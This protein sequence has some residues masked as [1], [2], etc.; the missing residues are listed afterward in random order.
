MIVT[1]EYVAYD[2]AGHYYY[3]TEAGLAKY[4]ISGEELIKLWKQPLKRL[5]LQGRLLHNKMVKSAYNGKL[6]RYRHKDIIE[7][8]VYLDLYGE[9]DAVLEALTNFAEIVSDSELDRDLLDGT[10]VWPESVL[11]PLRD[12]MIYYTGEIFQIVPEDEYQ[13]GY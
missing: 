9:R 2:T 12:A 8:N 6:E 4:V 3:Y 7:Y 11:S 10:A 1:N 13:V 5:K